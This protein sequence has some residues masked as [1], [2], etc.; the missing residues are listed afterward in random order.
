MSDWTQNLVS[1]ESRIREILL[2]SKV[3]AV[4]GL[5]D[6][7]EVTSFGVSAV[8][9]RKGFRIIPINPKATEILGEKV[10]ASVDQVPDQVD[11]V[12]IFRR[13]EFITEHAKEI[14]KMKHRPRCV[15]MQL[16]IENPVAARMLAEAG[17][18]VV[19]DLCI[20]VEAANLL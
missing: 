6:R 17:I 11:I 13:P 14:L 12:N 2:K 18:L 3:I 15:W 1:E 7:P 16:G 4:I 20:K 8:M 5:S 19:Q 9:Q 10:Y